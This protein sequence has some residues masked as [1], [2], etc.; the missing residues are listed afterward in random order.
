MKKVDSVK[1]EKQ[2]FTE[3]QKKIIQKMQKREQRKQIKK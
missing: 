1:A 3:R 2:Q